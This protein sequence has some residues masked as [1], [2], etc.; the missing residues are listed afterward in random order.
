VIFTETK[1][2]GAYIIELEPNRDDRGFFARSF[3]QR[4]FETRG[5]SSRVAQCNISF[6]QQRG[7][8]RGMHYQQAPHSEAKV[9][10]CIAGA[11]YDVILD[12]RPESLTFGQW[13]GTVL[14]GY[15]SGAETIRLLYVPEGFAHGYQTL[16]PETYLFYQMSEFYQSESGYGVRWND[17]RFAIE[18]PDLEAIISERDRSYPDF[19]G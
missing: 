10:S 13:L 8:L 12:L 6:N 1:L 2:K 4:E 11:V 9:V 17:P 14:R 18:W 15:V 19:T 16:E 5:L 7:T 3:C